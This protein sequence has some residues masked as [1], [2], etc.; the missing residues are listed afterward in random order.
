[1]WFRRDL[2]L[3]DNPALA[4][5]LAQSGKVAPLF[6]VDDTLWKPAGEPRR[7]FL[8]ACLAALDE[9]LRGRLI[10]RYGKP[11]EV[12]PGLAQELGAQLVFAAEDFGPYGRR[13]DDRTGRALALAGASL[14]LVGS[15]YA[16]AP[17]GVVNRAGLPYRVFTPFSR[18]WADHGWPAPI[19]APEDPRWVQGVASAPL[20][21]CR[22]GCADLPVA[23]EAAA[24]ALARRFWDDGIKGLR[25]YDQR[26]NNLGDGTSRLSPYLRWGCI[27][28]RQ[29]LAL[30]GSSPAERT[31]RTELC[32]REFYAD[33]L[34][35]D[36]GS[37]RR[38]WNPTMARLEVDTGPAADSR[39]EAWA[40]GRTGYPLVDAGMRQLLGEGWMHN[41]ARMVTAS[42]LVKDLHIDWTRGARHFMRHLADGDLSSNQHGWQWVAGTGTDASPFVRVFNPVTQ[43]RRFDPDGHYIRRHVPELRGVEGAAVHEPWTLAGGPPPGYPEPIVDHDA[44]RREALRRYAS[45]T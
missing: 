3:S 38:S 43:S 25:S 42:F 40:E 29:L 39:F 11:E 28:P 6:V 9:T 31:F 36:P 37:A 8:V 17:G 1:M 22:P 33:V 14:E 32:W 41:R 4:A 15:P 24:K 27:H 10:T 5:A 18:A 20:P 30:L 12:V 16:V 23:G 45:R 35:H 13:R 44:E 34:F 26:R 2:R 19:K 7:A 21:H